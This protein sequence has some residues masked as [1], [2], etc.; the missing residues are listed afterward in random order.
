MIEIILAIVIGTPALNQPVID[1]P[2][3]LQVSEMNEDDPNWDCRTMGN[4][5]CGTFNPITN[6]WVVV[7]WFTI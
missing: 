7:E 2:I 6:E 5:M 1:K 4:N 3:P